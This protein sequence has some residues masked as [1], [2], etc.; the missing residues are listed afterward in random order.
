M[1][2]ILNICLKLLPRILK[3]AFY[4]KNGLLSVMEKYTLL[5]GGMEFE[6]ME[7]WVECY[8][9]DKIFYYPV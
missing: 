5:N 9:L 6:V 8:A 3:A 4:S 1:M 7:S 2:E